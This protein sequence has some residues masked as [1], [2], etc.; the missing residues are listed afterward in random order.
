MMISLTSLVNEKLN[1]EDNEIEDVV[2]NM[3]NRYAPD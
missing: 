3:K 2:N 1:N